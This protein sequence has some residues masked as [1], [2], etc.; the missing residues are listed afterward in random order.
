MDEDECV[1]ILLRVLKKIKKK[2]VVLPSWRWMCPYFIKCDCVLKKKICIVLPSWSRKCPYFIRCDC[3]LKK[4]KNVLLDLVEDERH[5]YLYYVMC[6]IKSDERS[7]ILIEGCI[8]KYSLWFISICVLMLVK[9]NVCLDS[10]AIN[11]I[12]MWS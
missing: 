12:L 5:Y 10:F 2:C 6:G 1:R 11:F 7:W 4:K 8:T 3:V 9:K